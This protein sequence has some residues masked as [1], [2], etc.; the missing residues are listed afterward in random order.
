[1][2][3]LS[4]SR[5]E[6][7]PTNESEMRGNGGDGGTVTDFRPLCATGYVASPAGL[8]LSGCPLLTSHLSLVLS[9]RDGLELF[10]FSRLAA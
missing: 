8:G 1:M 4:L 6:S 9:R 5:I 7:R 2:R 3:R 10:A